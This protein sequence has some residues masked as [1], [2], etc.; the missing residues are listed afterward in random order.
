MPKKRNVKKILLIVI[1]LFIAILAVR[2]IIIKAIERDNAEEK[3]YTQISDFTSV[4]EIAE[5]MGCTYIKEEESTGDKYDIDIY[6][7]FKY[8]L[9][10]ED[11]SNED[12]YYNMIALIVGYL[13]YQNVRLIDQENDVVIAI[14]CDKAEEQL[15]ELLI[16]GDTNY[17]GTQESLKS[18]EKYQV[19]DMVE[20][21]VQSQELKELISKG[22]VTDEV[23]F[24][25]KETEFDDYDIFFDEGIEVKTINK[26][27]FNIIFTEKYEKEVVNGIKVNTSF[28]EIKKILGTPTFNHSNYVENR[29]K[30]IGYIG[31]KG[32]DIYIFFSENEISIYRIE[33]ADTTTNLA[34]AIETFN[35]DNEIREFISKITDTWTDY[36]FYGYDDNSVMLKYTLRG[37]KIAFTPS[38]S[39]VYVYSNYNG[40]IADGVTIENIVKDTE[41]IPENVKMQIDKDLVDIYEESRIATY[42]NRYGNSLMG[43]PDY[44]TQ[45]FS[46]DIGNDKIFFVSRTRKYPNSVVN[47]KSSIF[48]KYSDT[49]FIFDDDQNIIYKYDATTQELTHLSKDI[50]MLIINNKKIFSINGMGLYAYDIESQT[51][52]QVLQFENEVTGIYKYDEQSLIIGIKNMGIYRFYTELNTL[53]TLVEGQ[54]QYNIKTIYGNK[55][56]Y[57]DT[58]TIVK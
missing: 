43:A 37:I 44:S 23:D 16:N 17:F 29:E 49:E 47:K 56:F 35:Q 24:G 36:D 22:W 55:V 51:L 46:I 7:K 45:E 6:L 5:Y 19:F 18:I 27:V 41:L 34:D 3:T 12:Y 39:G 20:I 11:V 13:N 50:N 4:K 33:N 15:E 30:E 52:N 32:K 26:K 48:I 57:D 42:N 21:E 28:E 8:P 38:E 53:T 9:Y 2:E 58:L 14:T 25:T 40:Y 54:A 31:Y 1:I 10:T